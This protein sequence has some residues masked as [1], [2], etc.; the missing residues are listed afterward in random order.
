MYV[1][2]K[3]QFKSSTSFEK[4]IPKAKQILREYDLCDNCVGRLFAK[5]LE[6]TSNK[7]LGKRIRSTLKKNSSSKCYICKNI[8]SNIQYFVGQMFRVSK[9]H[10]YSSFLVGAKLQPSIIDRDDSIRS[11]FKLRGID[12]VK[13]DI[14]KQIG[15]NFAKKTKK[16]IDHKKP[17]LAFT[18]DFK[19][20]ICELAVRPLILYGRY[21]KNVRGIPQKQTRCPSCLGRGCF[22]CGFHGISEFTSIEGRI[23]QFLFKKFHGTQTK[24]AWIGGEDKTSLVQG[25]GRPFFV[26]LLSP[27]KRKLRLKKKYLQKEIVIKDLKITTEIPNAPLP[28]RSEVEVL[29]TTSKKIGKNDIQRL[30]TLKKIPILVSENSRKKI[31]KFIYEIKPMKKS[32]NSF[33]LR[34]TLDGGLPLKRFVEGNDISPNLTKFLGIQCNCKQFDFKDIKLLN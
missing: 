2:Q 8:F 20:D 27:K 33:S 14:T 34:L 6:L 9:E 21:T 23:S 12:S 3:Q 10:Q 7:L 22:S 18:I 28:F 31:Q 26:K 29:V 4:I 1:Q 24:I 15:K 19:N 30:K 16:K 25:K 32:P 5:N 11:K 13:A 17:D